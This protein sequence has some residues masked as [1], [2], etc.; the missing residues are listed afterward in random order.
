MKFPVSRFTR[1]IAGLGTAA[2]VVAA[3]APTAANASDGKD[4]TALSC[5]LYYSSAID[6]LATST[7]IYNN[8]SYSQSYVCP[9]IHDEG[10]SGITSAVVR[11]TSPTVSLVSCGLYSTSPLGSYRYQ[12]RNMHLSGRLALSFG[13]IAGYTNGMYSIVCNIPP[14]AQLHG[15]TINEG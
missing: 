1:L 14:G 15:Y 10:G 12:N 11:Y 8:L 7:G 4:Y 6:P 9:A 2:T 13:P 5:R 3:L